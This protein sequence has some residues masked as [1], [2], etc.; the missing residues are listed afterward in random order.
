MYSRLEHQRSRHLLYQFMSICLSEMLACFVRFSWEKECT[1]F[2]ETLTFCL[3][4]HL[5]AYGCR[6]PQTIMRFV[7]KTMFTRLH[8]QMRFWMTFSSCGKV[9][10][11]MSKLL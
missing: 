5:M 3:Y 11:L 7:N 2:N 6:L 4:M 1:D 8:A 9:K 10:V